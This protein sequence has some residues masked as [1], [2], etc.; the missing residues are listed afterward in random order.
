MRRFLLI[1]GLSIILGSCKKETSNTLSPSEP[2][3]QLNVPYGSDPAQKIDIYLPANRTDSTVLGVMIHGGSWST[4]DKS[5]FDTYIPE[6]QSRL[7]KLA[8]ANVNYRLVNG[9]RNRFPA[10]EEDIQEVMRFLQAKVSEFQISNKVVLLGVSAGAQLALLQGYKHNDEVQPKAI[11]SLFGPTDLADLYTNP[12]NPLTPIAL[13]GITG[14]SLEQNPLVYA[15]A[16][17]IN[18][19]SEK[20]AP[21]LILQGAQDSLVS[22]NQQLRLKAKLEEKH[23]HAEL[24]IYPNAGHGF[25]GENLTSALNEIRDFLLVYG[26]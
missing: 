6:I 26:K 18:Y 22:V 20:S 11:I 17:P 3:T 16:S 15:E 1:L 21:T 19:V 14:F 13:I 8:L 7:P 23:V 12:V 9:T 10:Q 4:G 2:S 24:V 25:Y 5:E